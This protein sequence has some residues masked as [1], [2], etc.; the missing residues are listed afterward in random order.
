MAM[1][2]YQLILAYDGTDFLGSQRQGT[3]RTV[4]GEVEAALRRIG[5]RGRSILLAGRTD[6]GVH[7]SGQVAAVDLDWR[8]SLGELKAA[9]NYNLPD[10]IA[11]WK[12]SQTARA[13]HPRFDAQARCYL[14]RI[15]IKKERDPLRERFAWRIEEKP[16]FDLLA[17][18]AAKLVGEHDFHN[19]GRAMQP[20]NRTVRTVFAARWSAKGFGELA[21]EVIADAFLYHMVRRM[22]YLQVMVGIGR[23]G[24]EDFR[25]IVA[26]VRDAPPGM[27]PATG[28]ELKA[29][30]YDMEWQE[31]E[32]KTKWKHLVNDEREEKSG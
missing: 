16:A 29:C 26:G 2:R 14:Y 12:V 18:A 9:L 31:K 4:Q 8:H 17:Q 19:L 1:E 15:I 20:Q 27:A 23:L 22:V 11:V 3:K 24:L 30:F 32:K 7:A 10:D 28:L 5:W 13:F 25:G 6:A 21:F